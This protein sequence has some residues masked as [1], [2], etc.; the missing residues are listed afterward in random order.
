MSVENALSFFLH[1]AHASPPSALSSMGITGPVPRDGTRLHALASCLFP[2]IFTQVLRIPF[3]GKYSDLMDGL[4][5]S[6]ST[7]GAARVGEGKV[8][9]RARVVPTSREPGLASVTKGC[10]Y[11]RP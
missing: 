8:S 11:L 3:L 6:W 10:Q 2:F 7:N 9:S 4:T 1:L 5:T